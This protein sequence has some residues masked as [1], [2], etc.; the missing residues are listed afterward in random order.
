LADEGGGNDGGAAAEEG[1]DVEEEFGG[2][3]VDGAEV[4]AEEGH[5][6][7]DAIDERFDLGELEG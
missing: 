1:E 5:L 3:A 7:E 4:A 6:F 2:E